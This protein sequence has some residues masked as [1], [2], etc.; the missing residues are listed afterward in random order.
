MGVL[1]RLLFRLAEGEEGALEALYGQL[2]PLLLPMLRRMLA[3]PE[4]AEEVFHD[5][6]LK[7][8]AAAP[9]FD[10]ERASARTFALVIARN[11]ALSRLRARKARPARLEPDIHRLPGVAP[12]DPPAVE[13]RI[14]VRRALARLDPLERRL[15]EAAF[16][17]GYSHRELAE[18]FGLPLGTVKSRLRRA[19]RK[20][21]AYL[22]EG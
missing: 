15:L 12:V 3:S 14:R 16:Y 2:R 19:L 22:E 17:Q 8:Q 20:L 1:E 6:L 7:L 5:A 11:L 13:D 10:P 9:R 18:A 21:R 4:E